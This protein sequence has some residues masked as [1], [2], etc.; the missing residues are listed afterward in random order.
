MSNRIIEIPEE[1][2][3]EID[4]L[5]GDLARI[6]TEVEEVWPGMG[7]KIAI[8]IAQLF[9]GVPIYPH[10]IDKLLLRIRDDSI[11]GEYDGGAKVKDLAIKYKL[12]TRWVENILA[13]PPSQEELKKKQF[14]LF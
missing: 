3:P 6:A 4:E 8:L 11:R 7:V 10:N 2:L 9:K 14:S 12:S 1:Y 5:P 13:Q